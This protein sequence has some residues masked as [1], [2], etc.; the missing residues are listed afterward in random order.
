MLPELEDGSDT[1]VVTP[2]GA[3]GSPEGAPAPVVEVTAKGTAG[4]GSPEG[5]PNPAV[6]VIVT[7]SFPE[8]PEAVSVVAAGPVDGRIQGNKNREG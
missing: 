2:I 3:A 4:R 7:A 6:F 5:A 1:V 8:G